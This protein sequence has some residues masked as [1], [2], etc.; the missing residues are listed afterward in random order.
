[1]SG[2]SKFYHYKALSQNR[3]EKRL[4]ASSCLC[5]PPPSACISATAIRHIF[6]FKFPIWGFLL[7]SVDKFR[8]CL[9]A[10]KTKND[11]HFKLR[12]TYPYDLSPWL[13]FIINRTCS[14][15]RTPSGRKSSSNLECILHRMFAQGEEIFDHRALNMTAS[16]GHRTCL[17][18]TYVACKAFLFN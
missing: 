8:F 17:R 2:C 18:V 5:S 6:L 10:D 9:N 3:C 15:R 16:E 13:F 7:I 4:L 12:P 11:A 1:M 14:L